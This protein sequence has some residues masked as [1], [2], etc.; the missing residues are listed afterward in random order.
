MIVAR[1]R[2]NT[3]VR[4]I[5]LAGGGLALLIGLQLASYAALRPVH[6]PARPVVILAVELL[7]CALMILAY[8]GGV[9]LLE[10]RRAT[11]IG[12]AG[13]LRLFIPGALAGAAL[14]A[15]LYAIL[16]QLGV[17]HYA[18]LGEV[19]GVLGV[20]GSEAAAAVSE[21]IVFRGGVFRVIDERFGT[22]AALVISAV[23]FGAAHAANRG[24]T[25]LSST[26]IALEAGV[27]LAAAYTL[28][29]SLWLPIG[30]HFGWNFTEGGIFGAA[31]SGGH[32]PSLLKFSLTGTPLYTGGAFGPE[33]SVVAMIVGLA[34]SSVL[35]WASIRRRHWRAFKL[36]PSDVGDH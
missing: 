25:V 16:W 29:R 2:G 24:A 35:I 18:G 28:A 14:F 20:V 31:V 23:L 15:L 33:A 36:R 17:A 9:Q 21:E 27:L 7:A 8:R 22:T 11:E 19:S 3:G 34:A 30:M 32:S 12:R 1:L 13:S 4:I 10:R 6:G 5:L 26:A